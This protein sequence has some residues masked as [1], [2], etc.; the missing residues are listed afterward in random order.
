MND[1][2]RYSLNGIQVFWDNVPTPRRSIRDV[3]DAHSLSD[4]LPDEVTKEKALRQALSLFT[5]EIECPAGHVWMIRGL[6]NLK[7]NG[8]EVKL[9]KKD[10][11]ENDATQAFRVRIVSGNVVV[12]NDT[13][14]FS[15]CDM[16]IYQKQQR[17]Q[18][19][20]DEA[21]ATVSGSDI[22]AVLTRVLKSYQ[23]PR[24]I[25]LRPMGGLYWVPDEHA[26]AFRLFCE[27]LEDRCP[28]NVVTPMNWEMSP[29]GLR[30]VRDSMVK[31]MRAEAK[32]I[33]QDIESETLGED[34]MN[35]RMRRCIELQDEVQT[36]EDILGD[37]AEKMT[38]ILEVA[39]QAAATALM[40]C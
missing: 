22:G 28:G 20:F 23:N 4:L 14:P 38:S 16:T 35:N 1:T 40:T 37:F 17:I 31:E 29:K 3:L 30:A 26:H 2:Q 13:L 19:C 33:M 24:T 8:Y 32:Q 18:S 11:T 5:S 21:K 39:Q 7:Q 27:D 6:K 36:S 10:E 15:H 12:E 25:S 34:A 9:E